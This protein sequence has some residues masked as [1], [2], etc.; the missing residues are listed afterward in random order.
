MTECFATPFSE[1]AEEHTATYDPSYHSKMNGFHLRNNKKE[2]I[3]GWFSTTLPGGAFLNDNTPM[4]HDFYTQ[5]VN[6]QFR[7]QQQQQQVDQLQQSNQHV[8]VV[9]L[10]VDT[11]LF[12]DDIIYKAFVA[13]KNS[14]GDT[15][16]EVSVALEMSDCEASLLRQLIRGQQALPADQQWTSSTI[17]AP[18]LTPL[19]RLEDSLHHIDSV[20]ESLSTFVDEVVS[21]K[22]TPNRE[23]G[24]KLAEALQSF[25]ASNNTSNTSDAQHQPQQQTL[26][27]LHNKYQDLLMVSYLSTLAQ[28]QVLVAEKLNQII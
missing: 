17:S 18:L 20:L 1:D 16:S 10:V 28:S 25:D 13:H 11:S 26:Q 6:K 2:V 9:H 21:Q 5:E 15:F 12:S 23:I 27:L 22:R 19:Q 8:P 4:L 14:V 3:V 7:Q 24:V